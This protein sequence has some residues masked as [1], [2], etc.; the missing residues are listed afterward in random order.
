M[1]PEM[2]MLRCAIM[3]GGTSKVVYITARRNMEGYVYVRKSVFK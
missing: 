1:Q 3:R 2:E